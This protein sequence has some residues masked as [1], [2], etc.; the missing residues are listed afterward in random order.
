MP[1]QDRVPGSKGE[2]MVHLPAQHRILTADAVGDAHHIA[3]THIVDPQQRRHPLVAE[4]CLELRLAPSQLHRIGPEALLPAAVAAQGHLVQLER[5][6][7]VAE[8]DLEASGVAQQ[9]RRHRLEGDVEVQGR[10]AAALIDLGID[11][12]VAPAQARIGG[13]VARPL[14]RQF[15]GLHVARRLTEFGQRRQ[16]ICSGGRGP[17]AGAKRHCKR[18]PHRGEHRPRPGFEHCNEFLREWP[19][20]EYPR[21]RRPWIGA[22]GDSARAVVLRCGRSRRRARR[23]RRASPLACRQAH[24]ILKVHSSKPSR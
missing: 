10:L 20:R 24:S 17:C 21:K 4:V 1:R 16:R 2:T 8:T 19:E 14:A 13:K 22:A 23:A 9:F 15:R 6:E 5:L 11:Q 3:H 12:P 18:Q 7:L